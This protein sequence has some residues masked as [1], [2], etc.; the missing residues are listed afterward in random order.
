MPSASPSTD[1]TKDAPTATGGREMSQRE[2][3]IVA[4]CLREFGQYQTRRSMFAG[5]WEEIAELILP[6][7]RNT[8][9]FGSYNSPGQKKSQQQVDA[10]GMVAL[11]HNKT[12]T[13]THNTPHNKQ[14][15]GL[16]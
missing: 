1:K 5:Q 13:E 16:Q 3:M 7:A 10:T 11:Q 15:H 8:F 12:N 4:D 14:R 9:Y 2:L 6:T